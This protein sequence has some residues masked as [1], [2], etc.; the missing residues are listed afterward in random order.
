MK[1][2]AVAMVGDEINDS[3]ALVVADVGMAISAGTDIA[4]EAANIVLMK[5]N[6]EDVVTAIDLSRKTMSRVRL[7]YVWALGYTILGMPVATR[8]W[9][10]FSGIRSPLWLAGACMAASSLSVVCSS[11]LLYSC[12][13]FLHIQS[14][15]NDK[16]LPGPA[17]AQCG[18]GDRRGQK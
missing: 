6:L 15:S 16:L 13:K 17:Q 12:K 11:L 18:L 9:F 8:V 7:N 3:P 10:P 1:G 4:I 5:S 14:F 2:M